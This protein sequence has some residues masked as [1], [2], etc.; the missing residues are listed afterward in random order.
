MRDRDYGP[1]G[2]AV[3]LARNGHEGTDMP[4]FVEPQFDHFAAA[5]KL[6]LSVEAINRIMDPHLLIARR[7]MTENLAYRLAN[8]CLPLEEIAQHGNLPVELLQDE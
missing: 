4:Q 5:R 6:D 8:P 7:R 3:Y 1:T 2:L